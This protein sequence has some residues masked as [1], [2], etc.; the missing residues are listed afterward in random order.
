MKTQNLIIAIVAVCMF[1][2]ITSFSVMNKKVKNVK[3]EET[4][5]MLPEIEIKA[6]GGI[7]LPEVEIKA[8]RIK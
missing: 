8:K 5:T 2:G 1:I 6:Y 7:A 3:M 4:V